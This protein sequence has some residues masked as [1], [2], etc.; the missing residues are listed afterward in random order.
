[1]GV[2]AFSAESPSPVPRSRRRR[3]QPLWRRGPRGGWPAPG[4]GCRGAR[5]A[6]AGRRALGRSP[7]Y[8]AATWTSRRARRTRKRSRRR[9]RNWPMAPGWPA[10]SW[11]GRAPGSQ[12]GTCGPP[13]LFDSG[14]RPRGPAAP[15]LIS[16]LGG[17]ADQP[18][19]RPSFAGA[20]QAPADQWRL[21]EVRPESHLDFLASVGPVA[22]AARLLVTCLTGTGRTRTSCYHPS[23]CAT[24][25]RPAET[26]FPSPRT[27]W[28]RRRNIHGL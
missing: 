3:G 5:G 15:A 1:M 26:T 13:G 24:T 4:G 17:G 18:R 14:A 22:R 19:G 8:F 2:A 6:S 7:G 20:V 27:A 10:S 11:T 12:A 23:G 21:I 28:E 25:R 16:P 9:S